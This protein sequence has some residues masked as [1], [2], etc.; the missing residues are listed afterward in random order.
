[1]HRSQLLGAKLSPGAITRR[2]RNGGLYLV[3]P[4]VYAVGHSALAPLALELATILYLRHDAV[5]SH[6]SAA[7]LWGLVAAPEAL[8]QAT[9]IGRDA[10]PR[11]GLQAYR[12]RRLDPRDIRVREG[13]PVT[14]PARTV[15]DL[16]GTGDGP[17]VRRALSEALVQ[18][19]LSRSDLA[20]AAA[21]QPL[22]TGAAHLRALLRSEGEAAVTR[23]EAERRIVALIVAA[24]LPRPETNVRLHGCEVD[25]LWREAR[26]VVEVD[27]HA[28]H[29]HRAAFE[30]DRRRDQALAAAGYR[31][32]RVTWRQ[33]ER[34]P[35]AVM[36]RIAQALVAAPRA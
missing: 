28:F 7:M 8:V 17:L 12:V 35:L 18:R 34:E 27:G 1:M 36:A 32:I 29:G 20:A 11:P 6:Q 19:L 10:R 2:V 23:S 3:L 13:I 33:L 25:L 22:R 14:S 24:G 16:A 15:L 5:I 31:V 9:I 26:L 21:R 30:R 4:R